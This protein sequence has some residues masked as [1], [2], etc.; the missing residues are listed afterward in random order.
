MLLLLAFYHFVFIAAV[1]LGDVPIENLSERS[2][3]SCDDIDGCRKLIDI[4]WSC[5]TTIFACTWVSLHP[6]I[7]PVSYTQDMGFWENWFHILEGFLRHQ[8][9]P[10][11]V[12]LLAPEWILAWAI[13][14]WIVASQIAKKEGRYISF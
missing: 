9:L 7:P 14:Q 10:F 8:L 12:A 6:N 1:P 4:V 5:L 2:P 13:Q 11:V 3:T